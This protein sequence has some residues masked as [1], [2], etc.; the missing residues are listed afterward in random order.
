[1]PSFLIRGLARYM[2]ASAMERRASRSSY[3][4]TPNPTNNNNELSEA[5]LSSWH[6]DMRW[7]IPFVQATGCCIVIE[8]PKSH[9]Q[10][11]IDQN[12]KELPLLTLEWM[13]N[14]NEQ[15]LL[16]W[17]EKEKDRERIKEEEKQKKLQVR[18]I[19]EARGR[20]KFGNSY[21]TTDQDIQEVLN[22]NSK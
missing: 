4:Y 17:I 19:A 13:K 11:L 20:V 22:N 3:N 15:E 5:D 2:A 9:E 14:Y 6:T 7:L 8:N 18:Q 16:E 10:I 21:T 1:M 12:S